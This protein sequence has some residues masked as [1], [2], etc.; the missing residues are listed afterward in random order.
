MT[1][2]NCLQVLQLKV[3]NEKEKKQKLIADALFR[4]PLPALRTDVMPVMF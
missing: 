3:Q 2:S 4:N 1:Y